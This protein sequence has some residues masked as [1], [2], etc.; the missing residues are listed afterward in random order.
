[1]DTQ[2]K[3]VDRNDLLKDSV[4][5]AEMHAATFLFSDALEKFVNQ[6]QSSDL[7]KDVVAILQRM[8]L[9]WGLHTLHTYSDQGYKSGFLIGQQVKDIEALYLEV[10]ISIMRTRVKILADIL[11]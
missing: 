8:T 10:K 3:G 1:M 7:T 11:L 2:E 5:V 6:R 4:R 9:L